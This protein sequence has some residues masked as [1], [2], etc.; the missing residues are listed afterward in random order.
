MDSLADAKELFPDLKLVLEI[1]E[2]ALA[3]PASI[4]GLRTELAGRSGSV[5]PTTTSGRARPASSSSPR[6]PPTS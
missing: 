4:D 6:C 3:D 2:G 1:H 5:S